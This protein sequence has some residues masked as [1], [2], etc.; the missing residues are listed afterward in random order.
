MY[1]HIH[2]C[3]HTYI[4]TYL[5]TY[6]K[7]C[8]HIFVYIHTCIHTRSSQCRNSDRAARSGDSVPEPSDASKNHRGAVCHHPLE[9]LEALLDF[10]SLQLIMI[11]IMMIIMMIVMM[12]MAMIVM[13]SMIVLLLLLMMMMMMIMSM[14]M[15]VVFG[16]FSI[17]VVSVCFRPQTPILV[18]MQIREEIGPWKA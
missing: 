4:H 5:S 14:V 10:W 13:M 8:T 1:I 6:R 7:I 16:V 15:T 12:I 9:N 17:R 11:M 18:L 3:M 2:T